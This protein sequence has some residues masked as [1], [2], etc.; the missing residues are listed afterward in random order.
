MS[1]PK[2]VSSRVKFEA[3]TQESLRVS[4]TVAWSSS[5]IGGTEVQS[6]INPAFQDTVARVWEMPQLEKC[7]LGDLSSIHSTQI[8][9]R[10]GGAPVPGELAYPCPWRAGEGGL[11][12]PC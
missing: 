1:E 11:G 3:S 12:G 8:K 4:P 5:G 6:K 7:S 2:E 9:V 10:P